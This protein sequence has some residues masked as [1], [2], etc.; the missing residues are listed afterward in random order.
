MDVALWA[1][2]FYSGCRRSCCVMLSTKTWMRVQVW[3]QCPS[4]QGESTATRTRSE[5]GLAAES[6]RQRTTTLPA[7]VMM[8]ATVAVVVIPAC[9]LPDEARPTRGFRQ[10][11]HLRGAH[12]LSARVGPQL[13]H[14]LQHTEVGRELALLTCSRARIHNC[15]AL[16]LSVISVFCTAAGAI[17]RA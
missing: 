8:V 7:V 12:G 10:W 15:L 6:Q 11:A 13:I 16:S 5:R 1:L 2:C 3:Q 9:R 14:A 17:G 4:L